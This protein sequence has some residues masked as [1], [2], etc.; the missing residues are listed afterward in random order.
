MTIGEAVKIH[1]TQ[2]IIDLELNEEE[3]RVGNLDY[4]LTLSYTTYSQR[5]ALSITPLTANAFFADLVAHLNR[6]DQFNRNST[7][8]F[9]II[10]I[11]CYTGQKKY[12]IYFRHTD[13]LAQVSGHHRL[14]R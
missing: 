7:Y 3:E 10:S 12:L 6:S 4:D 9:L 14:V 8:F 5:A 1:N 13:Q 11:T 2:N